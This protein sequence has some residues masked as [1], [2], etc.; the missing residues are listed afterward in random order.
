MVYKLSSDM[1]N[2]PLIPK[3][4][5]LYVPGLD[6]GLYLSQSKLLHSFKEFFGIPRAVLALSCIA[7]GMQTIDALLTCK[8]KRKRDNAESVSKP[9][10]RLD[11]GISLWKG[12]LRT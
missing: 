1:Q 7:D 5:L 3:V 6:A 9:V 12:T 8:V 10:Q 2:K 11:Q 4:V